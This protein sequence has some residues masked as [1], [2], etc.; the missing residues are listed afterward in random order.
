MLLGLIEK[1]G[2]K[3]MERKFRIIGVQVTDGKVVLGLKPLE[4][5]SEIRPEEIIEKLPSSE[6]ERIVIKLMKAMEKMMPAVGM[7]RPQ[8]TPIRLELTEH[9]YKQIGSPNVY[10]NVVLEFNVK[11]KDAL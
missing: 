2:E 8:N 3:A 7:S 6:E 10:Q 4:T 9:E 5:E 1:D 11:I